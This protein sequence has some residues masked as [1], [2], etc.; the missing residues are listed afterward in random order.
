MGCAVLLI[1]LV[2]GKEADDHPIPTTVIVAILQEEAEVEADLICPRI[3]HGLLA[4]MT[5]M[6]EVEEA[7]MERHHPNV[8]GTVDE[9][10]FRADPGCA[11]KSFPSCLRFVEREYHG[12]LIP[13]L[14]F[15]PVRVC[16]FTWRASRCHF[17]RFGD[18]SWVHYVL[19]CRVHFWVT[20][21]RR[22]SCGLLLEDQCTA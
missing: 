10:V 5:H 15:L 14:F 16:S 19:V 6:E 8:E 9:L 22:R 4:M 18:G 21:M 3:H 17:G 20:R 1:D 7:A 11:L 2:V 12:Y 13:Y